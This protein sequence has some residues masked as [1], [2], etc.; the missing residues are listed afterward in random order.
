MSDWVITTKGKVVRRDKVKAKDVVEEQVFGRANGFIDKES[1]Y[2]VRD[3]IIEEIPTAFIEQPKPTKK[4]NTMPRK[5][6]FSQDDFQEMM[7]DAVMERIDIFWTKWETLPA[8]DQ[9]NLFYKMFA[10]AFSKAPTAKAMD[11]DTAEARRNERKK[12]A[13][14]DRIREGLPVDTD[15]EE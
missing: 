3:A 15:F 6:N 10:Y 8:L 9:C 4:A 1:A 5:K 11:A 7:R 14:A 2:S 12:E 13:A